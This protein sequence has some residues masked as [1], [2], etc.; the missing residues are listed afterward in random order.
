MR[1]RCV[2]SGRLPVSRSGMNWPVRLSRPPSLLVG[3]FF[4]ISTPVPPSGH[5]DQL[6]ADYEMPHDLRRD[7]VR[8]FLRL[9]LF[10]LVGAS[11]VAVAGQRDTFPLRG[12]R[13]LF[14]FFDGNE[15]AG[16]AIAASNPAM[17]FF[18]C[19]DYYSEERKG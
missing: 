16:A 19:H 14:G 7:T 6:V 1:S 13:A 10:V 9:A 8:P 17:W 15:L 11:G 18:R 4:A 5:L 2:V 3:C 12:S